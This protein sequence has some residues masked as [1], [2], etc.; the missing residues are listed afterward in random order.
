MKATMVKNL[1]LTSK[2]VAVITA[3]YNALVYDLDEEDC[4][5]S[6]IGDAIYAIAHGRHLCFDETITITYLEEKAE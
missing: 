2:E 5:M 4:D 3:L 1:Q 6:D